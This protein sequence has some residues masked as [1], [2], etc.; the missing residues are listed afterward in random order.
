MVLVVVVKLKRWDEV[1]RMFIFGGVLF[2]QKDD[3]RVQACLAFSEY[4]C[5]RLGYQ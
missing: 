4:S 1:L 3:V 2:G 5:P